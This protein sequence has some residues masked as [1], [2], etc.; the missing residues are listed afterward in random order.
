MRYHLF[1]SNVTAAE[2]ADANV[3][4]FE[5]AGLGKAPFR[6]VGMVQQDLC[7]GEA[8]LSRVEFQA[9]GVLMTTKPGG[10]CAYCGTYIVQMFN[11]K[12][13][14]G[15]TFHVGSDCV[16]KTGDKKLIDA[17]KVAQRKRDAVKRTAKA[18]DVRRELNA[19]LDREDVRELLSTKQ[20]PQPI[21]GWSKEMNS[22]LSYVIFLAGRGGAAGRLRALRLVKAE[23]E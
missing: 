16:A 17:A 19:L 2:V 15:R 7:Y 21:P 22:L 13:A 3:H 6:F 1:M 10:S 5:R 20:R 8:I 4:P 12:S 9:T 18:A 11:V 14:D 23:V